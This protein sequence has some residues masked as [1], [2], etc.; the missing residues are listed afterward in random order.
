MMMGVAIRYEGATMW[1]YIAVFLAGA[2]LGVGIGV[3]I[4]PRLFPPP[5][6][7][8]TLNADELTAIVARG[9]FIR[10]NSMDPVRYG[11]GGVTVLQRTVFLESDFEVG[12]GPR[13]HVYLVP[14]E[15]IRRSRDLR[16][17][18]F[19][20]LGRLRAFKGSQKYTVPATINLADYP[21][22]VIWS[23]AYRLLISPADLKFL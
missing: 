18:D 20:D 11:S 17:T 19:I 10:T 16:G 15:S 1:R 3:V 2:I 14:K 12:P 22:V 8:D 7:N 13:F 21:S 4:F 9:R 23:A 6:A 5:A